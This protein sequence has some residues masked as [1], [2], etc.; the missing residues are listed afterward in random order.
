M[1]KGILKSKMM[2]I[3]LASVLFVSCGG[4]GGGGGGGGSSNLPVK[5]GTSPNTPSTPST[6]SV[7]EDS[8]PKINNPLDGQKGNMSALKTNLYNAQRSS[9]AVI[10][11]DT[12]T[13]DGR[14]VKVAIL[15]TNF[16]DPVR[17]GANSAEDD[18]GNSITARRNKTLTYMYESVE[19]VNENPNHPYIQESGKTIIT[20]T[21][22]P[23]GSEHGEQVL[24]VVG[25][26]DLAPNNH[27]TVI[28]SSNKANNKIGVILGSIGWD[29]EYIENGT[30]KKR[31]AGVFAT[32]EVY[33]AAMAR[34]GSQ[35]VKIF[36]QSFGAKG[37][38]YDDSQY[39]TYKGEGNFPLT[40]AK[41]NSTD[42]PNYML[43]YFRDAVENKGGLFVWA[44]G[45]D[46]NKSSSLE[47]GLP[48]FDN[49]LEKGWISVVGVSPEKDGKYNVLDKLSKAGSEAAYWSISATE[50]GVKKAT[51]LYTSIEIP[52]GSSFAAPKVTRAAALVY[53]KYD[54]MTADQIRQTLFTTTDKTELTQDPA[55]MSEANLRNVTMFPDST[56][57]WGM[58]NEKRALKGPGAFMDISKYG[59]TSI[60]KANLPAGKTSYF[61]NDI[62][63]NG[64]LEKLGAGTLHLTGNNSFSG[65][66]TVTAGTL[67]IH[68]IH[69]SP[70]TVGSGGTLVL[71]PKAI[72]GYNSSSF[73]LIGTVD[74]QK[75]TDSGIKVKNYGNVKFNGNTA[76]I[77]GDYVAY[78]GS[79]TQ[80]GFKNSVK[81]L[82]TIRIE[83][84]NISILS[85]GYI[86]K[87]ETSTVMEAK[88]IE[89]NIA[90]V[91]TNGMR[92]ANV[93]VKDGKVIA[94]LSRQNVVDYVGEEASASSKNV[95]EN[96]EKVFEDLDNKIEKGIATEREIL[97]ARTLQTMATSTF[98]SAT[99]VMSGEIYASA[100]ALTLSQAQDVNR[101]LSNRFSRIDNLKNS[102]ADTEVWF[103]AL[104]G[105]GKLK[106]EGYASADT[107][108][109]GGQVGIDK[110]FTPTTT[111]GVA[112]NYSYAHADF[113]K[114]AGE[115]KSDMVGLSLYGK[116]DL[117]K[118]FY[119]AAR[120]GVANVSSKVERELLTA[121]GDR[122]DG[123]I[124]HHDKILS[125][126]I[127]LGKKFSWFTPFIG[128]S[129]DYLRRGSFDE[130]NATWGIKADK[131]TYRATNFLVGARAEYVA[132]K[133]KLHASISHSI[134]TDKRDLAYEGR[135]TGSNVRQKYYGVKQAKH[136][137]WLGFGVFREISPAFGVYGNIDFRLESNKGRDSVFSTGIQY[138]F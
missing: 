38:S 57:G 13:V 71:N 120:L 100:Q 88:S 118:D 49:K 32:Q 18:D 24:E 92:T 26:L 37:E 70:I 12:S 97:A 103:S 34:F 10:P 95:A 125:T 65:G 104:G 22:R 114:Y 132:D 19:I 50:R 43:P 51:A 63:G 61:D 14:G 52:I 99:E 3:A 66:S 85:N 117:G 82:G 16:V 113:N 58:L 131:K 133:Y 62:Y 39:S 8:Y 53:D 5:P 40:F 47:A 87:N 77:G 29:Y 30:T 136:T 98:T 25:N 84:A 21:I 56:Y 28:G 76:I 129:Q 72:V 134:N 128:V 96:V 111:L 135:F 4:G 127:E 44:A 1:K 27:A 107:R 41:M 7:P 105:A 94:T 80:V 91:E 81:V 6:P 33:E 102:N 83:N 73:D 64:G 60:F 74:P 130:S 15:D 90:N 55:T 2:L 59:D 36:N 124:N 86:T 115:S 23:T 79:N 89:G 31:I 121:T 93:E 123:K 78:N 138:R 68:Q 69:S 109:V 35:S 122:V 17:S 9:G 126:Y 46:Q 54:W 48:Y 119:L 67:E 116:Q 11:K 101:D 112:L 108:V 137:T 42:E 110:R 20:T 106:R 75:I 45:N